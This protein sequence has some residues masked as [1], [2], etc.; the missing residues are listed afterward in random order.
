ML[1]LSL[2]ALIK[3]SKNKHLR[4]VIALCALLTPIYALA[5]D[6]FSS[7]SDK[8]ICRLAKATPDNVEYQAESTKRGLSCGGS[9][10]ANSSA[11]SQK[12]AKAL[13]GIDI[14][15]DPSLDFFK[16]PIAPYPTDSYWWGRKWQ[17]ADFNN[18]G[19]IDV[20]YVGVMRATNFIEDP[21]WEV[22]G[23]EECGDGD[24]CKGTKPLPSLFLGD[25]DGNL[26]YSPYLLIDNREEPGMALGGQPIVADYNDDGVMDFYITDPGI[27]D[28]DGH[29]DSYFLSQKDGTWVESSE[30]HLSHPNFISANNGTTGDIDND[31]DMDVVY[32]EMNSWGRGTSFWC[33]M[34]DGTGFLKKRK[35]GGADSFNIEL[36]DLDGDGDLDALIGGHEKE[37]SS[38][39]I[40]GIVWNDGR[41]R[42]S[43]KTKLPEHKQKWG[44]IPEV[45][46]SD[47]DNDGDLDIVYSRTSEDDFYVGAAIQI[48]ENLGNKKFKDHGLII[49]EGNEHIFDIKFRDFDGDGDNDIYLVNERDKMPKTNG[50]V[51]L[52]NGN[53]NFDIVRP[54]EALALFRDGTDSKIIV[55]RKKHIPT[56]EEQAVLDELA[57]FE[58]SLESEPAEFDPAIVK[59]KEKVALA[60]AKRIA[61]ETAKAAETDTVDTGQSVED[62]IAAFE[63]ELAE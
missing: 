1:F 30:T 40:T 35:C 17:L 62:E 9:N 11:S 2:Q 46:A 47:L 8:T 60:K 57:E 45:S 3:P 54:T 59:R 36:A 34:N 25:A 6:H 48:I 21:E 24:K 28:Y 37:Y 61:E 20:F 15:H 14:E 38:N 53:F 27:Q 22:T 56:D 52:N 19:F 39:A 44:A 51:L 58:A 10:M 50:T 55:I 5:N 33:L 41:G 43:Q 49:L 32:T 12:V 23:E 31:G 26:N 42:F 18:D 13:A 63:A 4:N 7:W 29:R 16:P